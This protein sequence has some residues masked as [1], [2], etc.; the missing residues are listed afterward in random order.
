MNNR[1]RIAFAAIATMG[2]VAP[3]GLTIESASADSDA[4]YVIG[5]VTDSAG[6]AIPG[7]AA[8][9]YWCEQD[10][11][12]TPNADGCTNE[13]YYAGGN[14]DRNGRYVITLSK[15]Y[16]LDQAGSTGLPGH[17]AVK[18]S[19]D[20]FTDS[21]LQALATPSAGQNVSGPTFALTAEPFTE[22]LTDVVLTG[23]VSTPSGAAQNGTVVAYDAVTGREL[24][25][26]SIEPN[27]HFY[28]Y[29]DPSSTA[30]WNLANKSVKLE[31]DAAGYEESFNGGGL[32]KA[33]APAISVP[34]DG[35]AP[36]VVNGAVTAL[37]TLTGS[38]KLPAAGGNWE[39]WVTVYDLDGNPLWY[40]DG[41]TDA[42][43]N[44][45]IDVPPGTYY[46]RADGD[47]FTEYTPSG[48]TSPQ[49][50]DTFGFVAGYYGK[51][52][53][54]L[55][56][57]SK[58]VVGANGTVSVGT[59]T[60][61]NAYHATTKPFIKAKKGIKKGAKLSVGN[62]TWNHQSDTTYTYA[63]KVGSKT[64][65]TKSSLKIT[66]KVWK[67]AL[68]NGKKAKKLT[69][70]VT[71]TDKFGQLVDGSVKQKVLKTLAKEQKAA[72]KAVKKAQKAQKKVDNV[73]KH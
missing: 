44:F 20:N 4:A 17:W 50:V 25:E 62:G 6:R 22:D 48:S 13:T 23:A 38:V 56:T 63:W 46:V 19:A 7:A 27:G 66:K 16:S 47:R 59:I 14:A 11:A 68:K 31:F 55:A 71:A 65:S 1:K 45:S 42:A 28:F 41:S 8:R 60:L 12:G 49:Q 40:V 5:K 36:A 32:A 39:A 37:G 67:K 43:G 61:T 53:T 24:D 18:A 29:G 34:A 3:L 26:E 58:I 72:A 52:A 15:Y 30:D 54:S 73:T 10:P 9:A 57:A 70:T 64:I 33:S 2:L 35:Q 21:A 51:G 69:V